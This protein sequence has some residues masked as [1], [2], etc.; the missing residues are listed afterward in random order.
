[1]YIRTHVKYTQGAG[2]AAP[3][4]IK[5]HKIVCYLNIAACQLKMKGP[6]F[7]VCVQV[8]YT[9]ESCSTHVCCSV[10]Q[11]VAVRYSVFL[12]V[13][14]CCCVPQ[15]RYGVALVSRID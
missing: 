8:F 3:A 9:H 6:G 5:K 2:A 10:L 14:K 4:A 12:C 13:T 1:M 11:R 7:V 15:C